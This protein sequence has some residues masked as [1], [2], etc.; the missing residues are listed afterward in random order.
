M[1]PMTVIGVKDFNPWDVISIY[2]FNFFCCP[3]CDGKSRSKQEFINH[4]S[5]S[6]PQVSTGKSLSEALVFALTNPQYCD[7]LFIELQVQYM[8]NSKLKPGENILF[9]EIVTDIQNNFCTQHVLPHVLQKLE[10]LTKIY[11]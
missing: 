5:I 10:L 6:H 8:K 3:E 1:D 4:A 2:D 9:T 11:L 7:R